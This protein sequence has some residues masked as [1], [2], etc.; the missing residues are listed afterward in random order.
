MKAFRKQ[1]ENTCGSDVVGKLLDN[2]PEANYKEASPSE[3][4]P[5]KVPQIFI[6]GADDYAVPA[7]YSTNYIQEARNKGDQ[8]QIL[9]EQGGG[10]HEY[11][12]PNS[13]IWPKVKLA[14]HSLFGNHVV[15]NK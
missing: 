2:S 7:K 6:Y 4:L 14:L 15:T 3:L 11:I 13:L 8:I 9:E 10:H 1:G 12:V 5:L